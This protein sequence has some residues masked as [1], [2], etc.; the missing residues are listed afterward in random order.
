MARIPS[1]R[2]GAQVDEKPAQKLFVELQISSLFSAK[3]P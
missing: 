2:N 1:V 3:T